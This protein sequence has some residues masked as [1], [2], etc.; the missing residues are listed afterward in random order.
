[1]AAPK[2]IDGDLTQAELDEIL[3]SIPPDLESTPEEDAEDLAAFKR[4]EEQIRR[5]QWSWFEDVLRR[6]PAD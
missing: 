5:G 4:G 3:R 1:M 6:H 2:R